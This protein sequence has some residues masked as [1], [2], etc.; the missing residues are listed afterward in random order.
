MT[1]YDQNS[2]KTVFE[3]MRNKQL[4]EEYYRTM[5]K[6]GYSAYEILETAHNSILKEHFR[7]EEE[8][9]AKEYEKPMNVKMSVEVKKK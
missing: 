5:Y 8:A 6:D 1:M 2:Q 9:R 4:P 3:R 7:R